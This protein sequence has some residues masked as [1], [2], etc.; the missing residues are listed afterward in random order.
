MRMTLGTN[1]YN[2]ARG[3]SVPNP[4]VA[5]DKICSDMM[6]SPRGPLLEARNQTS[7]PK[8]AVPPSPWRLRPLLDSLELG[9]EVFVAVGRS[10]GH[11]GVWL[12][13]VIMP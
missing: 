3:F 1:P 5:K 4:E 10:F 7:E 8:L 6:C 2:D 12:S 13:Q 11:D 9:R